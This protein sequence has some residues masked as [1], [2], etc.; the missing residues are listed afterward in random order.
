MD[1][2]LAVSSQRVLVGQREVDGLVLEGTGTDAKTYA[3][4]LTPGS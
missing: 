4:N 2:H 3:E 1:T